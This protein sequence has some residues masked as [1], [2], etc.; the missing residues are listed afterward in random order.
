MEVLYNLD[1]RY[2][3]SKKLCNCFCQVPPKYYQLRMTLRVTNS[4]IIQVVDL[5]IPTPNWADQWLHYL[6][7]NTLFFSQCLEW[8]RLPCWYTLQCMDISPSPPVHWN[9]T[10]FKV[11]DA[12]SHLG[13]NTSSTTHRYYNLSPTVTKARNPYLQPHP[14]TVSASAWHSVSIAFPFLAPRDFPYIL[15]S[16]ATI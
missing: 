14:R 11:W 7:I 10:L 3:S 16:A 15:A 12:A 8:D 4:Y 5:Q 1:F 9:P 13:Y 6:I 2:I